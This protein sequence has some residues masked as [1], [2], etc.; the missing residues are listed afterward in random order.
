MV[1]RWLT[2]E[3]GDVR[4]DVVVSLMQGD[5]HRDDVV[6]YRQLKLS[7]VLDRAKIFIV[8]TADGRDVDAVN[9]GAVRASSELVRALHRIQEYIDDTDEQE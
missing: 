2:D 7:P 6:R 1:E 8:S 9:A 4:P 3:R 5:L